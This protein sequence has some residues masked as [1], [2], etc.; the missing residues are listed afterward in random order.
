MHFTSRSAFTR[1]CLDVTSLRETADAHETI[2]VEVLRRA[3]GDWIRYLQLAVVAHGTPR[4]VSFTRVHYLGQRRCPALIYGRCPP[5][6]VVCV[7][8][9]E[10]FSVPAALR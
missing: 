5:C 8:W 4:T 3:V 2:R 9:C 6:C 7:V 10:A 1:R